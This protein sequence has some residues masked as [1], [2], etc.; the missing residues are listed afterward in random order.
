MVRRRGSIAVLMNSLSNGSSSSSSGFGL[1]T[2]TSAIRS[3][4]A[5]SRDRRASSSVLISA[6]FMRA[7][8]LRHL[9]A[10][11]AKA[12]LYAG[13]QHQH[14]TNPEDRRGQGAQDE[15]GVVVIGDHQGLMERAL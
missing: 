10:A 3:S 9:G 6:S 1:G 4:L 8:P 14:E 12:L 15:H 13:P 11:V 2:L 5:R 7:S